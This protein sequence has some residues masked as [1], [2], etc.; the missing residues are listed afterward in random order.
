MVSVSIKSRAGAPGSSSGANAGAGAEMG[1]QPEVDGRLQCLECGRWY[2]A[3]GSHVV[4]GEELDLGTY[5]E[6]HGLPATLPLA[7]ADLR[8]RWRHDTE[9]RRER[10]EL[11]TTIDP[12][13]RTVARRTALARRSETAARPGVRAIH[14]ESIVKARTQALN[15]AR[16]ALD[17]V[18]AG[19]GH[20]GWH[21]L[22]IS[23]CHQDTG[24]LA[25]VT[26]RDRQTITYWRRKLLGPGWKTAGGYLHPNRAA[27]YAR[28]EEEFTAR[29]WATLTHALTQYKAGIRYLARELGTTTPTLHAWD[30]HRHATRSS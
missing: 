16:T 29:G 7:A 23:T 17:E 13:V 24:V 26:G 20:A 10:G 15:N 1:V 30:R 19:L 12:D 3:L 18:A 28:I 22:I 2:R 14:R 27:A 25:Q 4:Q 5:R 8:E 11:P 9:Q 6:R 21:E